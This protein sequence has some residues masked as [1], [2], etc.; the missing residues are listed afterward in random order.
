MNLAMA[1]FTETSQAAGLVDPTWS[2]SAAF[3]DLN[4]DGWI[5]LYVAHYVDWTWQ[6]HPSCKSTAEVKDVCPPAAF[7]GLQDIVFFQ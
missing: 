1:P 5:D 2:S 4:G 7:T 6:N 3:G